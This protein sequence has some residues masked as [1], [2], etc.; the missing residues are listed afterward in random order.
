MNGR[1]I[2]VIL[3]PLPPR[4]SS[5][6]EEAVEGI[7]VSPCEVTPHEEEEQEAPSEP[8]ALEDPQPVDLPLGRAAYVGEAQALREGPQV[9]NGGGH[10][11]P[12][13]Q[14]AGV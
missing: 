10:H 4:S 8:P 5:P 2:S 9:V 13:T 1:I 11:S 3:P 12:Q 14:Q 7:G 6:K